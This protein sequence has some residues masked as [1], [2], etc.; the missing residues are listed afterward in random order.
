MIFVC[1]FFV[2]LEYIYWLAIGCFICIIYLMLLFDFFCVMG[3]SQ[4]QLIDVP[5]IAFLQSPSP[6]G[7]SGGFSL[8]QHLV[9]RGRSHVLRT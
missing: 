9:L 6:L 7:G 2:Y 1:N 5:F 4:I 8:D 3:T